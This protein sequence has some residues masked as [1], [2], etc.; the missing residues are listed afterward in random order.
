MDYYLKVHTLWHEIFNNLPI[1]QC[2]NCGTDLD[3][4]GGLAMVRFTFFSKIDGLI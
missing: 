4:D 3:A 1:S 2:S